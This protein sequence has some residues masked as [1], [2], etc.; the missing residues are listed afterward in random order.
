MNRPSGQFAYASGIAILAAIQAAIL[1]A[2]LSFWYGLRHM[3]K[4][5]FA[6]LAV[7]GRMVITGAAT[8]TIVLV[9]A[10]IV[11]FSSYNPGSPFYRRAVQTLLASVGCGI[12]ATVITAYFGG[13]AGWAM[14]LNGIS[15][16][17]GIVYLVRGQS[18][19]IE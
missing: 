17:V 19:E 6:G 9:I 16:V 11:V 3:P 1:S 5:E 12:A 8:A 2:P 15:L 13:S 18:R 14:A 4:S 10:F 7:F